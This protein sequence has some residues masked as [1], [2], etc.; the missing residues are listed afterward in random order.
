MRRD[1]EQ[2][3]VAVITQG[4]MTITGPVGDP[5]AGYVG[6]ASVSAQAAG[7][8]GDEP[9]GTTAWPLDRDTRKGCPGG[10][11]DLPIICD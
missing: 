7:G 5:L 9:P 2:H 4:G 3:G 6:Y 11:S 1:T 8:D 10:S